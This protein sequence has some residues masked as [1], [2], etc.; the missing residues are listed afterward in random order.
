MEVKGR[1]KER[2]SKREGG[3]IKRYLHMEIPEKLR[4]G[5]KMWLDGWTKA[6]L[7]DLLTK[8]QGGTLSSLTQQHICIIKDAGFSTNEVTNSCQY[9][10]GYSKVW[11]SFPQND[12]GLKVALK[13]PW[14]EKQIFCVV[15]IPGYIVQ[16]VNK[17]YIIV[18]FSS[19]Y[20][21]K[22]C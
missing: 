18:F 16:I 8:T 2:E 13:F 3:G 4:R 15:S 1:E 19:L 12:L 20:V 17:N 5:G 9:T 11:S 10:V 6:S 7:T 22:Q 21:S 14:N